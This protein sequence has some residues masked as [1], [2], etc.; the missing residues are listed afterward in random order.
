M[1]T[2]RTE[3][4]VQ[5]DTGSTDLVL[6]PDKHIDTTVVILDHQPN[7]TY[8]TGYMA[9]P[10]AFAKLEFG[11]YT[12]DSQGALLCPKCSPLADPSASIPERHIG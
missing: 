10:V 3:F 9:G 1:L 8:G 6:V 4:T 2:V 12:V 5:L 7:S 11:N